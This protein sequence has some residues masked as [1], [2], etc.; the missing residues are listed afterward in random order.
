[1]DISDYDETKY[2]GEVEINQ[3]LNSSEETITSYERDNKN[4]QQLEDK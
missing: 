2:S 1:M 3:T 4:T